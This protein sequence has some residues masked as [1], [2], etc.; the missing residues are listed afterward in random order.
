MTILF[1]ISG[2][3]IAAFCEF[4]LGN[5]RLPLPL[6]ANIV[7]YITVANSYR[8]GIFAA[9][10]GG[11]T[12]DLVYMRHAFFTPAA[13]FIVV[14]A[15]FYW[16]KERLTSPLILNA[17]FGFILPAI[18]MFS[19]RLL[20]EFTRSAMKLEFSGE[21]ISE[22]ILSGAVNAMILPVMI[23]IFDL[24]ASKLEINTFSGWILR[25]KSEDAE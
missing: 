12:L 3:I 5:W 1:I 24:I 22:L 13:M 8:M 2:V 15:A 7:F 4:V 10:L 9:F 16:K 17:A 14:L 25:Q 6:I 23:I 20:Q 18:M 19:T 21:R 11:M